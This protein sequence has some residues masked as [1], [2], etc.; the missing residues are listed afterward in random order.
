MTPDTPAAR[1]AA[2]IVNYRTPDLVVECVASLV[3][4]LDGGR[5][6]VVVVDNASGDGS[7]ERIRAAIAER[8]WRAVQ[9]VASERNGGLSA[10]INLGIREVPA[11]AFLIL[12]SDT[13]LRP[14]AVERLLA[15][16]EGDG[17]IGLVGPRLEGLDGAPQISCFRQPTPWSEL[18]RG[19]ATGP[20]RRLLAR[21]E[22]PLAVR[23]EPHDADWVSFAAVLVRAEV[24]ARVGSMDEGYFLFFEDV[25]FC[26]LA[27]RAGFRVCHEPRARVVHLRG[28][29]TPVKA[30]HAARRRR[31]RYWY[32]ARSRFFRRAYGPAG[33]LGANLLFTI[34][35]AVALP[36]ELLG[37][38]DRH[39]VER[40]LVDVWTA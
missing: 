21:W 18:I 10:G 2:V 9:L 15:T 34:G 7:V 24:F 16:L 32:Q 29:S 1:L 8:G 23:D 30:L 26:R 11:R 6:A 20:V 36:R 3:P 12:N 33:L 39:T 5:D 31:P 28:R 4:Q 25:D 19:A 40:E 22:V 17:S 37:L 38:K 35:R 27:R 14:G 13:L